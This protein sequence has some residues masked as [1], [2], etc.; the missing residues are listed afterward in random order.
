MANPQGGRSVDPVPG[1]RLTVKTWGP[2]RPGSSTDSDF[3]A[4]VSSSTKWGEGDTPPSAAVRS[5]EDKG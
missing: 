5:K 1:G 4:S 3:Q 2:S